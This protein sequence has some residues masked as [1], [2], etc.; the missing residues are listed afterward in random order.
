MTLTYVNCSGLPF[1]AAL[2]AAVAQG[3][4]NRAGESRVWLSDIAEGLGTAGQQDG[5][6]YPGA[7]FIEWKVGHG[8]GPWYPSFPTCRGCAGL[9]RRW[10]DTAAEAAGGGPPTLLSL[11]ALLGMAGF[12][13]R[14]LVSPDEPHALLPALTLSGLDSLLP[15]TATQDPLP[16]LPLAMDT[17]GRWADAV[18][19]T[20]FTAATLVPRANASL[21]AVQAPTC[22]PYLA[23]TVVADRVAAFWMP[24][25]CG[26]VTQR[27]A[28]LAVVAHPRY[29]A[30]KGLYYLGWFNKTHQPN[31]ELL[32]ECEPLHRLLTLA[33]DQSDNLSL[34]SRLLPP[35]SAATKPF[36]Q[37]PMWSGHQPTVYSSAHAY[38]ALVMSDGDNIAE[39]VATLRPMIEQRVAASAAAAA[40]TRAATSAAASAASPLPPWTHTPLSWTVSNR[41]Q[42]WGPS[43][44]E[45]FYAQGRATQLDSFLMGPSGYGYVFP[46]SAPLP[47]PPRHAS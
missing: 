47:A 2:Q 19:A 21:L 4:V 17:R 14:V 11:E 45:W 26:N 30:T 8:G 13:G 31:P 9:R 44:L 34:L 18:E 23:D 37:P 1:H 35:S 39:D 12:R 33:S 25:M 38:V 3:L 15:V 46:G 7:R 5:A 20:R 42:Q 40:S 41:W 22:L 16:H 27:D 24:E 36:A 28:M 32:S 6:G 43:A 10:L 29:A